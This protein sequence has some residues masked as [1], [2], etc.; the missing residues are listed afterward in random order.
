MVARGL[1]L[2]V[3]LVY[4]SY[5]VGS[6]VCITSKRNKNFSLCLVTG[7]LWMIALFEIVALPFMIIKTKFDYLAYTFSFFILVIGFFCF[8]YIKKQKKRERRLGDIK[9]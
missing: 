9:V 6:S 1:I 4:F 3:C 5:L 7:F 2:L 8:F